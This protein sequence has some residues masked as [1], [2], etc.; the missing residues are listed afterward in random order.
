MKKEDK[1]ENQKIT[2]R[3]R[4]YSK[5]YLDIVRVAQLAEYA[6]VRGCMVIK[7]YGYAIWELIKTILD[8]KFKKTN[9][10]NAYFPLLIP[11]RFLKREADHVEGFSP[12]IAAVTYAGGKRL[13]EALIIRPT[14][15]T[16]IYETF[17][18]WITS[19]R[20]LPILI[21]QWVNV[22]R[23]EMRPRLF[24]RTTEFLWQEGHT[25]H[26]TPEEAEDRARM[27]VDVY[28]NF[29]E[30]YM[31]IPVITGIKSE[32]EKFAGADHTYTVEAMMQDGRA[33]QFSTSHNLGQKFAKVFNL[34]FIDQKGK[35]QHPWQTSWGLSTRTIGALI[36]VHGDDKGMIL[37]PKIAPTQVVLI[38]IWPNDKSKKMVIE[39]TEELFSEL[40]KI[41][42]IKIKNDT[43]D[44]SPGEKF[45]EW[46]KKGVPIR[47][48]FGPKDISNNSCIL[49]RR[50][51]NKKASVS[52]KDIPNTIVKLLD[53][54][55][56]SLYKR[57]LDYRNKK[58]KTVKTWK[59]FVR[60]IG[61]GNFVFAYW[62]GDK[63]GESK[64][65]KE[66][67][68]TLRCISLDQKEEKGKCIHCGKRLSRK[69]LFAR[70]Y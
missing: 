56:T 29:A 28:R 39:R 33:L 27:M 21:N 60:E 59:D 8:E 52:L 65:N 64:I 48:E 30:E 6:P 5:W 45:Y 1:H 14:S 42:G 68:A 40:E 7:P 57:A 9:V 15:E 69:A 46:E 3:S 36:M 17:S 26:A 67:G 37:P 18:K 44:M 53:D 66:T 38:P 11:E 13:K 35:T 12:E 4:N 31:A 62:C 50:D 22:L 49:V 63:K 20:D 16:I 41:D 43:R 58:T 24:L 47:I 23:W 55:Q 61:A 10:E 32:A 54:I 2:S 70:A 19:Y 51:T 25:V 34:K